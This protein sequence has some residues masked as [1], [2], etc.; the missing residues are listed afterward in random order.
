MPHLSLGIN[1]AEAQV[2]AMNNAVPCAINV[3]AI[4]QQ[5]KSFYIAAHQSIKP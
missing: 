3:P 1:G 5:E 4:T 2:V